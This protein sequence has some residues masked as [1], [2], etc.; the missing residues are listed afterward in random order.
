MAEGDSSATG[1]LGS[2]RRLADT[3]LSTVQNRVELFAVELQEE[4]CWLISTLLWAVALIFFGGLAVLLVVGTIV[5]LS[6][7]SARPWVLGV[8]SAVFVYLGINAFVGFRGSWR[9]KPPA[10]SD[11]VGEL[12]KDIEWIR[13]QD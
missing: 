9:E 12:K 13:S 11:T 2:V 10:L 6:P 7:D 1:I 8:F 4:K 5:Y 3:F